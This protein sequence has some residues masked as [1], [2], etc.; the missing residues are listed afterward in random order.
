M[1]LTL[2]NITCGHHRRSLW[3]TLLFVLVAGV[4]GG[5][6]AGSLKS[7][8][9]NAPA[10][11]D[12]SQADRLLQHA[13]GVQ[14]TA[15]V[16]L[17]VRTPHGVRAGT[18][19]VQ[20]LVHRLDE[21]AGVTGAKGPVAVA[22]NG[23]EALITGSLKAGASTKTTPTAVLSAFHGDRG[24]TVGGSAV[25]NEQIGATVSKDLGF[26]ELIVLPLLILLALLFFRGRAAL[27]PLVVGVTTVLGT[28]LALTGVTQVYGL[29]VYA[30]NL[31]IGLGLGLAVDYTLFILTRYRDELAEGADVSAAIR[32]AMT[33]AG[34]TV[35]FSAITVAL[36]L[37]TLTVFPLSFA[38][39]M[40]IAGAVTALVAAAAA[41]IVTPALLAAWGA[42]LAGSSTE[43]STRRWTRF[44]DG[45]MRRP[46]AI[47]I[48]TAGAMVAI[49][50]L[51]IGTHWTPVDSQVIPTSQSSRTVADALASQFPQANET[52]IVVVAT[53]PQGDRAA[54]MSLTV[55]IRQTPG[56]GQVDTPRYLGHDT[57]QVNADPTGDPTGPSAQHVVQSIRS[58]PARFPVHVGGSAADFVDQQ[59]AIASHLPLAI[60]LLALLTFLVLWLMTD[61]IILPLKALVMNTLTVGAALAPLNII[62]GHGRLTSILSYT[63]NGGVQ[64]IDFLVAAALVFALSTDYGVFLLGRISEA[65]RA[66]ASV[67]E[68]V[69]L[70]IGRTGRV[71]T[72]AAILLAVAIG[73]FATSEISFIQQIGIATAFGVLIDALVVRSL[74]V[75]SLMAL[76]GEANWWS[77]GPLRRLHARLAPAEARAAQRPAS[78]VTHAVIVGS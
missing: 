57:W 5:P 75:P 67:R 73:A 7:S 9:N 4:I 17:L 46:G 8:A 55:R 11:A 68:A 40:G 63:P 72:A 35:I 56:V 49:A 66:G 26:S 50:S 3:L 27:L 25:A 30:L 18:A 78:P 54:L 42:K 51:S 13:T 45:V 62:Y 44:A 36:A 52:P 65:H 37:A 43:R 22:R 41:L 70:G 48:L 61:S 1:L 39:S 29:S 20:T 69:T 34:R 60:G 38:I 15:G 71:L 2:S 33:T 58:L 47:A 74:L 59:A 28:F 32:T 12:S 19:R 24:V 21:V 77:P 16:V 23:R 76:L 10:S 6:L 14:S 53:A 31:V 64:P